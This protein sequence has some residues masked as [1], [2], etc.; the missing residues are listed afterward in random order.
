M[1]KDKIVKMITKVTFSMS[2]MQKNTGQIQ[3]TFAE[4]HRTLDQH[5]SELYR[6]DWDESTRTMEEIKDNW[7]GIENFLYQTL[8]MYH[9]AVRSLYN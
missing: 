4:G 5:M 1:D 7:K 3:S 8:Q 2:E 9:D 6:A